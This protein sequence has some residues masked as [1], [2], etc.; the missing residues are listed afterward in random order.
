M[1]ENKSKCVPANTD[2]FDVAEADLRSGPPGPGVDIDRVLCKR[3]GYVAA[4]PIVEGRFP[5]PKC[6]ATGAAPPTA[7]NTTGGSSTFAGNT[8]GGG[9]SRR[10]Q[11]FGPLF[12]SMGEGRNCAGGDS[13]MTNRYP[14]LLGGGN[15][16]PSAYVPG[17]GVVK[18]PD[19]K[20]GLPTSA[21][22]GSNENSKYF[23]TSRVPGDMELIPDPWRVSQS[24]SASNYSFKTDP[25]P[26]LTDF[27][28]FLK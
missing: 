28:A 3:S 7:G 2:S 23:P 15:V 5:V 24:F 11:I 4:L 18:T 19:T 1:A 6:Y 14:E 26:F 17:V 16:R 9:G 27:S 25:V 20:S 10:K 13:S 22:M 8:A 12:T 21:G